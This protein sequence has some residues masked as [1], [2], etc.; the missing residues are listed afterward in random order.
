MFM[1]SSHAR[2]RKK[3]VEAEHRLGMHLLACRKLHFGG[4]VESAERQYQ[5][6]PEEQ[7]EVVGSVVDVDSGA[8]C[9]S[10]GDVVA[11]SVKT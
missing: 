4:A 3:V 10:H 1:A 8:R 5:R 6:K 11:Q 7:H 2:P 9:H